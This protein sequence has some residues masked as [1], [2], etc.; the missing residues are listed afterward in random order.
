MDVD[1][2]WQNSDYYKD[3]NVAED[4]S[5]SEIKKQYRK[6]AKENHPDKGG[7]AAAFNKAGKAY[8]VLS[9]PKKKKL[10]D[11]YR[12][13]LQKPT[14][15]SNRMPEENLNNFFQ[16]LF[17]NAQRSYPS[18]SALNAT[19]PISF[20]ESILGTTAKFTITSNA[21]CSTCGGM[22][23]V[24]GRTCITCHGQGMV[25]V[26]LDVTANIPKGVDEDDQLRIAAADGAEILLNLIIE[27]D[28]KFIRKNNDLI[29]TVNVNFIDAAL[30]TTVNVM[31]LEG[32][33]VKLKVP[34]G[35]SSATIL[36]AK[37]RGVTRGNIKGDL[38]VNLKIVTPK[39]M[40]PEVKTLLKDAQ[41]ALNKAGNNAQ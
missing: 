6:L 7:N 14:T 36:R 5:L 31:L 25:G 33:T 13:M 37:G 23:A 3:L 20:K 28:T 16:T 11:K 15:G 19:L 32:E 35:S 1:S 34:Q 10:Y 2:D 39:N 12:V 38:L 27:N 21:T 41:V 24:N 29:T 4:A 40:S 18:S 8:E 9:D 30:G 17:N 26:P 22:G